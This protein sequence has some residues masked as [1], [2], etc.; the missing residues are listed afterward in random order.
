M[1]NYTKFRLPFAHQRLIDV[2]S[3]SSCRYPKF[4]FFASAV[5][6]IVR[7][8]ARK[9]YRCGSSTA[10]GRR[11]PTCRVYVPAQLSPAI[12]VLRAALEAV[13]HNTA[14]IPLLPHIMDCGAVGD[15]CDP[16]ITLRRARPP[17]GQCVTGRIIYPVS[18]LGGWSILL[19]HCQSE[20]SFS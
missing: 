6:A 18:K 16:G 9:S 12:S 1:E 3:S 20:R 13:P 4:P 5:V 10:N 15:P 19:V 2:N 11:R 17:R 14:I 7:T 8:C